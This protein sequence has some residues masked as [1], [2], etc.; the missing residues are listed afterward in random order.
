MKIN[1][2]IVDDNKDLSSLLG[3]C[4]SRFPDINLSG[5]ANNALKGLQIMQQ[6]RIDVLLL[7]I[8]MPNMDG[9]E[10]LRQIS[11]LNIVK[12][13]IIIFSALGSE[14]FK[15]KAFELGANA[16]L[17]KPAKIEAVVDEIRSLC[18]SARNNKSNLSVV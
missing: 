2:L 17:T 5:I 8:I 11:L 18:H 15:Q 7:D 3:S 12:P 4:I 9:F 14:Q 16:F 13:V 10:L 1:V 6:K